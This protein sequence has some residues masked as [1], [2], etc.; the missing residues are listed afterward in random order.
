M[1]DYTLETE[2]NKTQGEIHYLPCRLCSNISKHQVISS[3]EQFGKSNDEDFDWNES[4]QI[5]QCQGCE[6]LS[7]REYHI[8]SESFDTDPETGETAMDETIS[9]YPKTIVGRKPLDRAYLIPFDVKRI[10]DETISALA[11]KQLILSGIGIRALVEAVCKERTANGD[12]LAAKI[13]DL[14]N[15][16]VLTAE[17]AQILH[18]L[19]N[20]GNEA[21]HEVKPHSEYKLKIAL[22]VAEALLT[23]TYILPRIAAN[24]SNA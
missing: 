19:R 1:R 7:F 12:N 11:G 5:V 3:A 6:T 10:Y 2:I 15:Q 18:G 23:N 20:L 16:G 14:V 17:G 22:D 24:L 9:L 13:D 4:Y 8:D 21:A